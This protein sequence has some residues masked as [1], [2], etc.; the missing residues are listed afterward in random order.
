MIGAMPAV[1]VRHERRKKGAAGGGKNAFLPNL[2]SKPN[3]SKHTLDAP[4]DSVGGTSS[5]GVGGGGGGGS[6]NARG[7]SPM[8]S[9]M[10]SANASRQGSRAGSPDPTH[11]VTH[12]RY[13]DECFFG[14]VR[15]RHDCAL[16]V[17]VFETDK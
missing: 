12:V 9:Q 1:A 8:G 15:E 14:K 5:G 11:V 3:Q 2:R 16:L 4:S 10:P 6:C 7:L 13:G 17:S